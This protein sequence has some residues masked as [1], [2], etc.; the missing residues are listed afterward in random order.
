MGRFP[1]I[2]SQMQFCLV[3][4]LGI[5][6]SFTCFQ[7]AALSFKYYQHCFPSMKESVVLPSYE[8]SQPLVISSFWT[9]SKK[10][11]MRTWISEAILLFFFYF[12]SLAFSFSRLVSDIGGIVQWV[13]F[14]NHDD[15]KCNCKQQGLKFIRP[16]DLSYI[17]LLMFA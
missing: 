9:R 10:I 8:L 14:S 12:K 17:F 3:I 11:P 1:C 15:T 6:S 16:D 4:V 5:I 13:C 2:L 7:G